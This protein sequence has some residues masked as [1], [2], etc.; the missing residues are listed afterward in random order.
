MAKAAV[1]LLADIE[2][3]EGLARAVNALETAKEFKGAGDSVALVFDGAGTRW[4]GELAKPDHRSHRLYAEVKDVIAGACAFCAVA[5]QAK[6][7]VQREGITLLDEHDRHPS[8]RK[9]VAEGYQV[10]TF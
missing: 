4:I 7:A 1:V 8:L 5:F 6:E 9:Y 2:T 3:H 10:I